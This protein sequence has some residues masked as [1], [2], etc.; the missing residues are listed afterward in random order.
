MKKN[1]TEEDNYL[2]TLGLRIR[3]FR[4]KIGMTQG[5]LAKILSTSQPQVARIESGKQE[6]SILAY[7]KIATAL[8]VTIEELVKE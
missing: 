5:D 1:T 7:K 3:E 6:A 8:G 2:I 4:K